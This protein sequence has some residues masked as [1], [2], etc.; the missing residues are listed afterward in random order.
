MPKAPTVILATSNGTGMGHLARQTAIALAM[1]ERA[2]P[3]IFSQSRALPLVTELGLRGEYVPSAE[4]ELLPRSTWQHYLADRISALI[5]ETGA[6]VFAFDGVWPY[7]GILRARPRHPRVAFVWVRRPLWRPGANPDALEASE[8]FDLILEPGDL[9]AEADRGMTAALEDMIRVP[10][11]TLLEQVKRFSREEA[12]VQLGLDPNRPAALVTLRDTDI[13]GSATKAVRAILEHPDWQ[14]ATTRDHPGLPNEAAVRRLRY[15]F[16]LASYLAAFDMGVVEAG[17]NSFHEM[18]LAGIPSVTVPTAAAVT[19]DQAARS[20]WAASQALALTADEDDPDGIAASVRILLDRGTREE[21]RD[22]CRR[23][24]P[25]TGA[26]TAAETLLRLANQFRRHPLPPD[27]VARLRRK[28]RRTM[29][30]RLRR[31]VGGA[32]PS[33]PEPVDEAASPVGMIDRVTMDDLAANPPPEHIVP[34]ASDAYLRER[35]R[36]AALYLGD[37]PP[38]P[39]ERFN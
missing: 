5:E 33:Q 32:S 36:I 13:H 7:Y 4:R 23:L 9:A 17:Y 27:E 20:H 38:V 14:V 24:A 34:E 16:P 25:P 31:L 11:V 15:V 28:R 22:R 26:D 12:A 6:K 3:V 35:T 29:K 8:H 19:D 21:I 30:R 37:N 39:G 2:Q 18:I 10:P 1:G